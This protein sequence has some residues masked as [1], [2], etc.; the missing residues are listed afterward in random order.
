M[1]KDFD[2]HRQ[3]FDRS[4]D[5]QG[6]AELC[7]GLKKVG[8]PISCDLALSCNLAGANPAQVTASPG[9][10]IQPCSQCGDRLIDA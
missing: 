10:G 7:L 2:N 1:T 9:P 6:A 5:L 8:S 4:D 3:I